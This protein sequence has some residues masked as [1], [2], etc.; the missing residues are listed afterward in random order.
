MLNNLAENPVDVKVEF[1]L[2]R[3]LTMLCDEFGTVEGLKHFDRMC[4]ALKAQFAKHV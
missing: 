1:G 4:F 3:C 2:A